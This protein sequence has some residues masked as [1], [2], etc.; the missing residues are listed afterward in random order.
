MHL[1]AAGHQRDQAR[2]LPITH[3]AFERR[4][5]PF[6]SCRR[7]PGRRTHHLAS[8]PAPAPPAP[9]STTTPPQQEDHRTAAA[10][11]PDFRRARPGRLRQGAAPR[12]RPGTGNRPPATAP[13]PYAPKNAQTSPFCASAAGPPLSAIPAPIGGSRAAAA[14][15]DHH[16]TR[17]AFQGVSEPSE[18][19]RDSCRRLKHVPT[20]RSPVRVC[21]SCVGRPGAGAMVSM[22]PAAGTASP[23]GCVRAWQ[24]PG[25]ARPGPPGRRRRWPA[26]HRRQCHVRMSSLPRWSTGF[27]DL[28][29]LRL[30]SVLFRSAPAPCGSLSCC[31]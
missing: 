2:D 10:T 6:Q 23:A 31:G 20:R 12:P 5:Q 14:V 15:G 28:V 17:P 13:V 11:R 9:S 4:V 16:V 24:L 18:Y 8:S 7:Q 29:L 3:V 1:P 22:G 25:G 27:I 26:G 19:L 21:W 30:S